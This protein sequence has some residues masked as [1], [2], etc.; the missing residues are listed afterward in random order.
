[1]GTSMPEPDF[2]TFPEAFVWGAL[3]ENSNVIS[4]Q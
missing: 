3:T 4:S 1:V 2:P